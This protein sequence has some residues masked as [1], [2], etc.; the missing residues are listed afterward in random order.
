MTRAT[1]YKTYEICNTY[2]IRMGYHSRLVGIV[3]SNNRLL[4]EFQVNDNSKI[5]VIKINMLLR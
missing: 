5:N 1:L 2:L 3:T 4:L